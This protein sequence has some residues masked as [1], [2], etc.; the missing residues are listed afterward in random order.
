MDDDPKVLKLLETLLRADG[1]TPVPA[2]D[3]PTALTLLAE[4]SFDL[5]ISDVHM[6]P[7]DGMELCRLVRERYPHLP[8]IV[9]TAYGTVETARESL[10]NGAFDFLTKPFRVDELVLTVKRALDDNRK[11]AELAGSRAVEAPRRMLES[12]VAES[13]AMRQVCEQVRRVAPTD[14]SVLLNGESGT[15]KELLAKVLHDNSRRRDKPFRTLSCAAFSAHE[16]ERELFGQAADPERPGP[17]DRPGLLAEAQGGT[18]FLTEISCLAL[19]LQDKLLRVLRDREMRSVGSTVYV[20]VNVRILAASDVNLEE[21][22]RNGSFSQDFYLRLAVVVLVIPPLRE[23]PEDILPMVQFFL[24]KG[25]GG[26]ESIPRLPHDVANLLTRY[27]WPG[28]VRELGNSIRYALAFM[29]E[30]VVTRDSLPS[31]IASHAGG[32]AGSIQ[33]ADSA[34]HQ[35]VFLR[36]FLQRKELETLK[37]AGTVT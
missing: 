14:A 17:S 19:S 25:S 11:K 32:D 21:R 8:I 35:Q 37:S 34:Q 30:N 12:I 24:R 13:A 33:M 23:R 7:M 9:L 6:V 22:V 3:G 4:Q 10:R 1:Q 16:L 31:R 29:P 5:L 36:A 27:P 2:G 15:G 26:D 18:V 28:N 20:P